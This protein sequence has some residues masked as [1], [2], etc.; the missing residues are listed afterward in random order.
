MSHITVFQPFSNECFSVYISISHLLISPIP[1][2]ADGQCESKETGSE[3]FICLHSTS[4]SS[5]RFLME[6]N[7]RTH[8]KV[9]W[10]GHMYKRHFS[11]QQNIVYVSYTR[12]HLIAL[13]CG[14]LFCIG[15]FFFDLI[16]PEHRDEQ[17]SITK[18]YGVL[19]YMLKRS[20][21]DEFIFTSIILWSKFIA[22]YSDL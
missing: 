20:T 4:Q 12:R 6:K 11:L 14:G 21:R 22:F 3:L 10:T 2:A 8:A 13:P 16:Y 5:H 7:L 19:T 18:R 9:S 15:L 17:R 1:I